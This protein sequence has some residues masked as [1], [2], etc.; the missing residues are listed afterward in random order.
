MEKPL[1]AKINEYMGQTVEEI[2]DV[3]R[4]YVGDPTAELP[5]ELLAELAKL[6]KIPS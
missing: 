6:G 5:D 3:Y 4:M 1:P 2:R